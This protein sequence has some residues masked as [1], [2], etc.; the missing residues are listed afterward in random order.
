M[1]TILIMSANNGYPRPY[2]KNVFSKSGYDVIICAHDVTNE[3]VSRDSN[4][5]VN[6]VM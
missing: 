5:D 2:F 1:V 4:Y 3:I 6:V